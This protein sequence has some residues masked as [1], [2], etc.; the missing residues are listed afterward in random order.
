MSQS[1]LSGPQVETKTTE[2][3][4]ISFDMGV[5][6]FVTFSDGS[7]IHHITILGGMS[8]NF[9]NYKGGSIGI[10]D[11]FLVNI[12]EQLAKIRVK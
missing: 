7:F 1:K 2:S 3:S 6:R 12:N 4:I 5:K 11:S 9:V 10:R 8:I